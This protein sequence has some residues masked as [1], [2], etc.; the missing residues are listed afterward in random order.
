MRNAVIELIIMGCSIE[1]ERVH[2]VVDEFPQDA[3]LCPLIPI[4]GTGDT[5]VSELVQC[6]QEIIFPK[7]STDLL[8]PDESWLIHSLVNSTWMKVF[9]DSYRK[10]WILRVIWLLVCLFCWQVKSRR[11][12]GGAE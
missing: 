11:R 1:V 5:D 9:L 3:T 4:I 12:G 7:I 10:V 2:Q 8:D 6:A